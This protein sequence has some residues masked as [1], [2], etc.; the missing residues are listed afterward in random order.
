MRVSIRNAGRQIA[1]ATADDFFHFSFCRLIN[2]LNP[3]SVKK[4]NTMNAPFKQREN[5]EMFL[6]GCEKYGL[7]AQDL[8]QVCTNYF[9]LGTYMFGVYVHTY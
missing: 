8:F 3:G 7:Q 1:R 2:K 6:K 9:A 5:I 4:I